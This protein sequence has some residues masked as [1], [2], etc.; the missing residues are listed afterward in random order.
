MNEMTPIDRIQT[1][2]ELER[3]PFPIPYGWFMIEES[4]KLA[5][6]EIR[7]VQAFDQ[8]WVMFRGESGKVGVTDPFCPHLGAHL[9]HGGTVQGDNIRCPF[10]FWEYD[11]A[12]WCKKIPYAKVMPPLARKKPILRAL[13]V[14]ERYGSIFVWYHPDAIEP[15]WAVPDVPEFEDAD[16]VT[17]PRGSWDIGTAIQEIGENGVDFA[18]LHYLHGAPGIPPGKAS[19]EGPFFNVDIGNGYIVGK[20]H[21]PGIS[22]MHFTQDDVVMTMFATSL[23]VNKELTRTRM[24][25]THRRYPEGST[26]A[27][28]GQK[29]YEH[30]IGSTADEESAGFESVDMIVW[31]NKKYRPQPLLCD[32]DGPILLWR[33]WFMQFYAGRYNG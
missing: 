23:P 20:Q 8:E 16:F 26:E 32:G 22:I 33:Q 29:L 10:H 1:S 7:K 2:Q 4:A 11:T 14:E 3:C 30:S 5:P 19:A 13:P 31:D 15:L 17:L 18:H 24:Q 25:F 21:G 27:K 12:G 28:V 6:G 9:G